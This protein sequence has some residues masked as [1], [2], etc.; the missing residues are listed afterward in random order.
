MYQDDDGLFGRDM[1]Y[2][3]PLAPALTE[4]HGWGGSHGR[5]AFSQMNRSQESN[6][7]EYAISKL[8]W[9]CAEGLRHRERIVGE[10]QS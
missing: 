8:G 7:S 3:P 9:L 5:L 10:V 4:E 2:K 1:R 6:I